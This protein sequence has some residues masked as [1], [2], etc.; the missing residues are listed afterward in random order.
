MLRDESQMQSCVEKFMRR[1]LCCEFTTRNF[2][3][4]NVEFDV[5]GYSGEDNTFHIVECK[6]SAKAAGIGHA[7]GQLLAYKAVLHQAGFKFLKEVIQHKPELVDL[8][9][10]KGLQAKFYVALTDDACKN[11]ELLRVMKKYLGD[12]G[13]IRIERNGKC[14]DY[15]N[16]KEEGKNY[17]ICKSKTVIVPITR[18]FTHDEFLRA[19]ESRLRTKLNGTRFA[20]FKTYKLVNKSYG[21]YQKFWY[22]HKSYH[23]EVLL[24]KRKYVE[25][26]LHLEGGKDDNYSLYKYFKERRNVIHDK[27]GPEVKM[28]KWGN[29][30]WRRVFEHLPRKELTE[31][32]AEIVANKLANYITVLQPMLEEWENSR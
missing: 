4:Q 10:E 21:D 18:V 29:R 11:V 7:F 9:T 30:G 16:V 6:K 2:R 17:E 27:V 31:E 15:I 1:G 24:R 3:F 5:V 14:R 23:F 26:G 32:N 8:V 25:V 12:V 13:I 22:R 19:V 20:E 28:G